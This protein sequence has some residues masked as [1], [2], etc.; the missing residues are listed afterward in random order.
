MKTY[1]QLTEKQKRQKINYALLLLENDGF[2]ILE[3]KDTQD[4]LDPT[5]FRIKRTGTITLKYEKYHPDI[6]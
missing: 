2:K 3:Y 1:N 5:Y 6:P 4:P